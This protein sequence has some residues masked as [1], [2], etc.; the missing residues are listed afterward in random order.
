[1]QPMSILYRMMASLG[2]TE[3]TLYANEPFEALD[4][5]KGLLGYLLLSLTK[6]TS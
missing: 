4:A 5:D 2:C 6:V 3:H 1:M